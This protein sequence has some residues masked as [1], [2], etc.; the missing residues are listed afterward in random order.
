M[1]PLQDSVGAEVTRRI[2]SRFQS[3]LTSSPTLSNE[4]PTQPPFSLFDPPA[5]FVHPSDAGTP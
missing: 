2:L 3:L 4:A 1:K 5:S